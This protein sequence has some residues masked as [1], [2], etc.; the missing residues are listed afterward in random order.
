M[1]TRQMYVPERVISE[2]FGIAVQT[3][4]ND[5]CKGV[6]I[7]YVKKGKSVRYLIGD[8]YDYMNA[9]KIQTTEGGAI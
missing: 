5:R 7:P 8:A 2:L 3:L 4:R 1:Y 6:G 9:H